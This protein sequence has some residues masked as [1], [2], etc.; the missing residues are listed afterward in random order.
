MLINR[1]SLLCLILALGAFFCHVPVSFGAS[2]ISPWAEKEVC[3]AIDLG[4]I[5][6]D[7]QKDYAKNITRAEFCGL[8][9]VLLENI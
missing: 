2:A 3:E 1:K 6:A 9:V 4:L 5:P 7:M 8:M